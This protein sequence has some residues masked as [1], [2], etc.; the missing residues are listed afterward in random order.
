MDKIT[1]SVWFGSGL[2]ATNDVHRRVVSVQVIGVVVVVVVFEKTE[3][4]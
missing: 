2:K 3:F 4:I 1:S